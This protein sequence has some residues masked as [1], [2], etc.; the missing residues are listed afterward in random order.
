MKK[1]AFRKD[2]LLAKATA[3]VLSVTLALCMTPAMALAQPAEAPA[4]ET[5]KGYTYV[6]PISKSELANAVSG[7]F[8]TPNYVVRWM[9]NYSASH[10]GDW[11]KS[12]NDYTFAISK[13]TW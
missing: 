9:K 13:L 8:N 2:G 6:L 12:S 11:Y 10:E 1:K 7:T 3:A 5:I 4:K